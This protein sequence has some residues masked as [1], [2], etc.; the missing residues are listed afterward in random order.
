[1]PDDEIHSTWYGSVWTMAMLPSGATAQTIRLKGSGKF[2]SGLP[3]VTLS[4]DCA[5]N[6]VALTISIRQ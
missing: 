1:M 4:T 6:G 3:R 5:P 2:A